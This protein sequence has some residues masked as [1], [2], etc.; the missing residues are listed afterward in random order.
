MSHTIPPHASDATDT[1]HA[2]VMHDHL[3]NVL[4]G[5]TLSPHK[6]KSFASYHS[7]LDAVVIELIYK[8][9][10]YSTTHLRSLDDAMVASSLSSPKS[11]L[12]CP[13]YQ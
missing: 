7:S 10:Y 4:Y 6:P 5:R 9:T 1:S 13:N 11:S 8:E 12:G 2:L 3:L